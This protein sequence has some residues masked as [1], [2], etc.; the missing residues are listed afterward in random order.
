MKIINLVEN[1]STERCQGEHGLSFYI[2]TEKH[3]LLL[4]SG[5]TNLFLENANILGVDLTQ[6]DTA[7]LSHGHYDHGGGF[8][9]FAKIN[10][11][12]DIYVR[13]N[14]G[15][16]FY[17]VIGEEK[18]YIGID[19]EMMKLPQ[20]KLVEGD[21]KLDEELFLF[22]NI[23]GKRYPAWSNGELKE[24]VGEDY[25]Q[26]DFSHEQCL[27]IRQ[28]NQSVLLSGCAH[29]GILSILDR[30]KELF[31]SYPDLVI[32][33]F[34]MMKKTDYT[35]EEVRYI[36]KTAKEL[37]KTGAIFYSGHCTGR[38]A[39]AV[40]KKIMGEQLQP[41]ESGCSLEIKK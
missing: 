29:S 6:V 40:M 14:A 13:D 39:F 31:D 22:S 16:D 11:K 15:G 4:D 25:I 26:D 37:L 41:L 10:S 35:K 12:A 34:H 20:V 32:S 24:K 33:G 7:I 38:K 17:H 27:V 21:W 18:K 19:K 2:E 5:T 36:E 28:G 9:S 23:K 3:K 8:L 1:T 30:Y